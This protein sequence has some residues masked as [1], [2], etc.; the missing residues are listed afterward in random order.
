MGHEDK[1]C[2]TLK[3]IKER[4][5]DAYKMQAQLMTRQT[6]PQFG[7]VHQFQELP[8]FLQP[9]QYNQAPQYHQ[10]NMDPH[11]NRGGFRGRGRGGMGRGRGPIICHSYQQQGKYARYCPQQQ[12]HVCTVTHQIT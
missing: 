5:S 8:E 4:I 2:R 7:N 12:Q 9:P 11:G 6:A 1:N 10:Q 3:L